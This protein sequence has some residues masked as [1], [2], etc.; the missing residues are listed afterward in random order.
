MS[1][2]CKLKSVFK[3]CLQL[4]VAAFFI[5]LAPLSS[6]AA[7]TGPGPAN[8]LT[9]Q[10]EGAQCSFG[11]YY[12]GNDATGCTGT[13][14]DTY[15]SYWIE[16]PATAGDVTVNF[17]D[18]D[19]GSGTGTTGDNDRVRGGAFDTDARYQIVDP[20]GTTRLNTTC[21]AGGCGALD[22]V[23]GGGGTYAT[24]AGLWEIR[25]DQ[26]SAVTG[27]DDVNL[28]GIRAYDSTAS[29]VELNVFYYSSNSGGTGNTANRLTTNYPYV[30]NGCSLGESNFDFDS[31][32]AIS[33]TSR[34]GVAS[35]AL[36]VSGNGN[37]VVDTPITVEGQD[38]TA[39]DYGLWTLNIDMDQGGSNNYGNWYI[40]PQGQPNG[41]PAS[42]FG[43]N[44]G[45]AFRIYLPTGSTGAAGSA[46]TKPYL[47][48][49]ARQSN[50]SNTNVFAI[51]VRLFNPTAQDITSATVTGEIPNI[52]GITFQGVRGGFP[53]QGTF[54]GP[55][56]GA[57]GTYSWNIGTLAAGTNAV[58]AYNIN[59]PTPGANTIVTGA[60][61]STTGTQANWNEFTATNTYNTGEI[62]ELQIGPGLTDAVVSRF[63][64]NSNSG[65]PTVEWETASEVG[66]LG[67]YVERK[68]K[69]S[70][71][72]VRLNDEMIP[73]LGLS[74]PQGGTYQYADSGVKAGGKHVY[75][76]IEV[77]SDGAKKH[78]GPYSITVD[79]NSP[80]S[81]N[82]SGIRMSRSVL[83]MAV[84][85]DGATAHQLKR[86]PNRG[87][88][89]ARKLGAQ[90]R[91]KTGSV[92][93][94]KIGIRE[95]GLYYLAPGQI[96]SRLGLPFNNVR[97]RIKTG[98][99][100]LQ[101]KGSEVAWKAAKN[102]SGLYFYAEGIDSIYT[103]DNVYILK[104]GKGLKMATEDG[105]APDPS[106]QSGSFLDSL[107]NEQDK[108]AVL[109][110]PT[111]DY[112][113][114]D[115]LTNGSNKS[116]SFNVSGLSAGAN[117]SL[118]LQLQG[119][120]ESN[121]DIDV[122]V[123]GVSVGN[124][125]WSGMVDKTLTVQF[126]AGLL[127]EGANSLTLVHGPRNGSDTSFIYM[128][129]F[130]ISYPRSYAAE[131]DSLSFSVSGGTSAL[132]VDGF[133]TGDIKLL[134]IDRPTRPVWIENANIDSSGSQRISF[135]PK[136]GNGSYIAVAGTAV[137]SPSWI[138][139]D[140]A[141]HLK[142]QGNRADYVIITPAVLRK[143][144][145]ALAN[146]QSRKGLRAK[147]VLLEDIYDEF[148]GGIEDPSAIQSFL[149]YAW[150]NW[151]KAPRYA[152]LIGDGSY[153]HRDLLGLGDSLMPALLTSTP[154]GL[155]AADNLYGRFNNE[156][157]MAV[158]RIPAHDNSE[159]I[160]YVAKLNAWQ[161][162]LNSRPGL[163]QLVA[164]DDDLA[165]AFTNDS[166]GLKSLIPAG[167]VAAGDVYLKD[168][169]DNGGDINS[170]RTS[171]VSALNAGR[172]N[173]N[174]LGHGGMDRFAAEGVLT[175]ADVTGLTNSRTPYINA[176]SCVIN[177]YE[178]AG[179]DSLGEELLLSSSGGAI[180]V[181]SPTGLS[182]NPSAVILNRALYE[183]I[184]SDGKRV[185]GD[186]IVAALNKYNA[187]NGVEWMPKV[188]TL[189]GD[190]ALQIQ[191]GARSR[192]KW[193]ARTPW[194]KKSEE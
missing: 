50:G 22:Q 10:G 163:T 80:G 157:K 73:G 181:W 107:H 92:S 82:V 53:S 86:Q 40:N 164:D 105:G 61:G 114:W 30:T 127:L 158:G 190:P 11:D 145:S 178:I 54:T 59:V 18:M 193:N 85:K 98:K 175:T 27:G 2:W 132:T 70:G 148:N 83:S 93:G 100:S 69:A 185:L 45:R 115:W 31:V 78:Y 20:T 13:A 154:D 116:F 139:K 55:A 57:T 88:A 35:G 186:A 48:Q 63:S 39:E 187:R 58:V 104:K 165:G 96:A 117:A 137:K 133:S 64:V 101:H 141:S 12:T 136:G 119:F 130:D 89:E 56:I 159:V 26:S 111:A 188:Y 128:N 153:D 38:D 172:D 87:Q 52:A 143:G 191:R 140:R 168:V 4:L 103:L 189:L 24:I 112:W 94:M 29:N 161:D 171:L 113:Y 167:K 6:W 182:Q 90:S 150:H 155:F 66:T 149:S 183:A 97:Y 135:V 162:G 68:N 34:L 146:H 19:V 134:N 47:A 3:S 21:A 14:F 49:W 7:T 25:V 123:N 126:D 46:P 192:G 41:I 5:S 108:I 74:A 122:Q 177:R 125:S 37:W 17:W 184:Y 106:T 95:D 77:L 60:V 166:N 179:Y 129:E 156:Q 169:F 28:L 71:K 15:Y 51:T 76:L 8:L 120:S 75:R 176:L 16:V 121:H 109:V 44:D 138:R 151:R 36:T 65:Q 152:A 170:A 99:L 23:W 174:Y 32:G 79:G 110:Q 72:F 67:F 124:A 180:A 173:V 62:C 91:Q 131:S 102:N 144:A 160:S 1:E 33:L 118:K 147:V 43:L 42:A 81:G 84:G 142:K 194:V 9:I